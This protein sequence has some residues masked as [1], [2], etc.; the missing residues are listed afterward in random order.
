MF[1]TSFGRRFGK[2]LET[3]KQITAKNVYDQ[4]GNK[5]SQSLI[6]NKLISSFIYVDDKL[7]FLTKGQI[8][9]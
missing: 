1:P 4:L 3:S 6:G 9:V 5:H 7:V 2:C 8:K